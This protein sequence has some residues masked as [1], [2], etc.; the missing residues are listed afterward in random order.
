MLRKIKNNAFARNSLILF[1]GSMVNN[2]L[3]YI[4]HLVVG[5]MVSIEVYGET[6]SL[7][8]LMT[9]ISVP[10]ATLIMVMTRYAAE[11]KA[12]N[13]KK[14]SYELLK[15][16]NKK[17]LRYGTPIF[18]AAIFITPYVSSFLNIESNIPLFIVWSSMLLSLFSSGAYGML[19]GWQKF[20][21]AGWALIGGG[22]LKLI[23]ALGFIALGI[24]LN[25]LMFS[26]F[27]S[28]VSTYV[29]SLICL[30]FIFKAK[31]SGDY[32][33]KKI[34]LGPI[35]N[36]VATFFMGNLAINAL[37][38]TDMVLAKH[39]LSD[40]EAGQYGALT[41]VSKIIF[42]A[43]G[44]VASVL[45]SMS[46]EHNHK[47]ANTEKLFFGAL[48][49]MMAVSAI[50]A[51]IYF[52]APGLILF[53]LFGAKYSAVADYLGWFAIMVVLFSVVNLTMQ[54]LLSL[55]QTKVVYGLLSVAILEAIAI[56]FLGHTISAILTI[57]IVAQVVAL[58]GSLPFIF[59]S[60]QKYE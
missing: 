42:F 36:T 10:A 30:K 34:D 21:E 51:A 50:S 57:G 26:F 52:I 20:K 14:R 55:H 23:S 9:I 32:E 6:E 60:L 8:S 41:I 29:I 58:V 48:Y 24:K 53:I 27:L 31:E 46:A 2:V 3:N 5:R 35:K 15:Y 1:S 4:F 18:I 19:S 28:A 47:K 37:G 44:V 45:F 7:I 25:G 59:K 33:I 22:G 49:L 13:D 56:L 54:Y 11:Y 16:F 17:V 40:I 38:N 39:N 43:T 12:Q